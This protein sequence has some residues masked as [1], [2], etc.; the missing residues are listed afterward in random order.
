MPY[1]V[2]VKSSRWRWLFCLWAGT[3]FRPYSNIWKSNLMS[4]KSAT[5]NSND[6]SKTLSEAST[7]LVKESQD[8]LKECRTY[9]SLSSKQLACSD[10]E[11]NDGV[12]S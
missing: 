3:P 8:L 11:T 4:E 10:E 7:S 12:A 1:P 5:P 6:V 2:T 9:A